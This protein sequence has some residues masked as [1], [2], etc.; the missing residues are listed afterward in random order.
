MP[1]WIGFWPMSN[2]NRLTTSVYDL[3]GN[4]LTL[5][6]NN[7]GVF[8]VDGIMP[9][10][11][12]VV[13]SSQ[14]LNRAS[15]D[16]FKHTG[17]MWQQ[18]WFYFNSDSMGVNTGL[19][20]KWGAGTNRSYLIN[21]TTGDLIQATI[22]DDGTAV[23]QVQSAAITVNTW[24]CITMAFVAS[25]RLTLFV[26]GVE[27]ENTTSIPATIFD[28]TA[29]FEIGRHAAGNYFG[30]RAALC[31]LGGGLLS[32]AVAKNAFYQTRWS[33]GV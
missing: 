14:Y 8:A 12:F 23:A 15:E 1:R 29:D 13:A 7:G 17:S 11:G 10:L 22:T 28:S 5:T 25:T 33:F 16:A 21:K 32:D 9:Y 30:G 31:Q 20:G 18:G 4:N 27:T 19:M 6:K 26:N 24:Y 3:G 2:T